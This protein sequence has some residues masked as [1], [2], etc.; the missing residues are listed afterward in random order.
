[1]TKRAEVYEKMKALQEKAANEKR[2]MTAEEITEW[3]RMD[4]EQETLRKEIERETKMSMLNSE[5]NERM[6]QEIQT[7]GKDPEKRAKAESDAFR[8]Y[9]INGE[10]RMSAKSAE[11]LD[12]KRSQVKGTANVGG[13]LVPTGFRA[14]LEKGM[15]DFIPMWDFANIIRTEDGRD[16]NWPTTND[17]SNK[18]E[19][20]TEAGTMNDQDITFGQLTL[21]AY[22]FDSKRV[23]V[24]LELLQDSALPIET[25]V[26]ELLAERLGRI[27]G[28]YATTG[29]GSSQPQGCV[30]G[31]TDSTITPLIAGLTRTDIV[32]LIHS[33]DPNYRKRGTLM[34]NDSILKAIKLLTIG[35]SDARPLWQ[36]S[37]REGE[38]DTIEGHPYIINSEMSGLGASNKIMVFGD[39]KKFIIRIAKDITLIRLNE[40]YAANLLVGFISY[41]RA[42]SHILD[43]GTHPLKYMACDAS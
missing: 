36:P 16:I 31:A 27:I 8:D 42:S 6:E 22:L 18:G 7:T 5:M 25:I 12:E 43:A 26:A 14:E 41:M 4:G 15:S 21:K 35:S 17:T 38:P 24:S 9:M 34:M 30:Y 23:K 39:F 20:F 1:M 3:D 37:M 29:T 13:Y 10:V 32:G 28:Q 40:L 33:V 19:L 2:S 11:I